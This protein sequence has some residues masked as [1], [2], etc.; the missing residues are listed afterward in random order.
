ME[1]KKNDEG[2]F[3]DDSTVALGTIY[4]VVCIVILA[5]LILLG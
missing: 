3:F 2:T 1:E 4:T 5:G